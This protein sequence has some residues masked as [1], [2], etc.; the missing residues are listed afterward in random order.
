MGSFDQDY[1]DYFNFLEA[2]VRV[3]KARPWTEE[4]T[5]EWNDMEKLRKLCMSIEDT[6]QDQLIQPWKAHQEQFERDRN[7][8]PRLVVPEEQDEI[9][10]DED[11]Q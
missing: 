4:E 8:Q 1:L 7:Y 3:V 5:A 9:S 6:F 2:L 11:T 10:D